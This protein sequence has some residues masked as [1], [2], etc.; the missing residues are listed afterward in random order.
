VHGSRIAENS[1]AVA[2]GISD[3]E[4]TIEELITYRYGQVPHT[5]YRVIAAAMS[6][7]GVIFVLVIVP[8]IRLARLASR[9]LTPR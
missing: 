2:A 6:I 5:V 7:L 9:R 8:L 1:P 4:W 3:H